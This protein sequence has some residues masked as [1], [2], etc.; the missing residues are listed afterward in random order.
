M[1]KPLVSDFPE[2]LCEIAFASDPGATPVWEDASAQLKSRF[3]TRRGRGLEL[4]QNQAGTAT[5]RL[6]NSDRRFDPTYAGE[7]VNLITNPSFETNT[8]GWDTASSWF[9]N[10][11]ATL[12]RVATPNFGGWSG[13]V[14]LPGV[15]NLEGVRFVTVPVTS[16]Q[17]YTFSVWVKAATGTRPMSIGLGA[18]GVGSSTANFTATTTWTRYSVTLTAT[19]TGNAQA[20]VYTNGVQGFTFYV[21]GAQVEKGAAPSDYCDGDQDNCRWSGT[22]HASQSYRGGPYYPNVVP[23][24]R[25]RLRAI[26]SSVTYNIFTGYVERW[27]PAERRGPKRSYLEIECVDALALLAETKISGSYAQDLSS[28]QI[29][30]YLNSAGWP[31]ADRMIWGG[32][33]LM[34]ARD[35][36]NADCLPELQLVTESELGNLF[37]AVD[38]KLTFQG[39][40]YRLLN[41]GSSYATYSDQPSGSER[42]YRDA[43]FAHEGNALKNEIIVTRPGGSEQVA[44]DAASIARYGTVPRS[45]KREPLLVSDT[46]A[47][48][49]AAYLLAL[50]KEPDFRVSSLVLRPR[51]KTALW[52]DV[53]GRDLGTRITI[54]QN[55]PPAGSAALVRDVHIDGIDHDCDGTVWETKWL[56]TPADK[57]LYWQL[58]SSTLSVLGSTTRLAY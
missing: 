13:Q 27:P 15:A 43:P 7:L 34:Q 5:L 1:S 31:A 49:Y 39:R 23:F 12:T 58:D 37:V 6:D 35:L 28:G 10:A 4:D 50:H 40:H 45:L 16:G 19:G 54:E 2:V 8:T 29:A 17:T 14:G 22:A 21:D 20:A 3:S 26:W 47:G 36:E 25:V 18:S 53:L 52:P 11:G 51:M 44:S 33:S 46:E 32:Q 38:G 42:P 55:P 41:Y 56:T 48:D 9:L 57:N 30:A 24:R